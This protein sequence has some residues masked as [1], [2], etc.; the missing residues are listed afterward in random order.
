MEIQNLHL[1]ELYLTNG[2]EARLF[3]VEMQLFRFEPNIV[4]E[5]INC[6]PPQSQL[7]VGRLST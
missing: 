7:S 5:L 1:Q 2:S 4:E 6:R 3:V